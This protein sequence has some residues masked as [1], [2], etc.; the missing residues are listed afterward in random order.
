MVYQRV[1]APIPEV[2]IRCRNNRLLTISRANEAQ[3]AIVLI[4]SLQAAIDPKLLLD[5]QYSFITIYCTGS[6]SPPKALIELQSTQLF[7]QLLW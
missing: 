4:C 5:R 6:L 7:C 3:L 1:A 2:L